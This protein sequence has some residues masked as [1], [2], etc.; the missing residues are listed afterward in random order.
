MTPSIFML[1]LC[2]GFPVGMIDEEK[3]RTEYSGF[4]RSFDGDASASSASIYHSLS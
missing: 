2:G 1:M 3:Y 4:S